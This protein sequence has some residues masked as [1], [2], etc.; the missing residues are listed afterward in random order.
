MVLKGRNSHICNILASHPPSL[1]YC[2]HNNGQVIIR[3]PSAV[4][5]FLLGNQEQWSSWQTLSP[6]W[7]S[8][9]P[10]D[11]IRALSTWTMNA[12]GLKLKNIVPVVLEQCVTFS[13]ST[14]RK[15]NSFRKLTLLYV[16]LLIFPQRT[17][18]CR[19]L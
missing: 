6:I 16:S 14:A 17:S 19:E 11:L 2:E 13:R 7:T 12:P 10:A 18:I 5:I 3:N 9:Q 15:F 8:L 4:C 1:T